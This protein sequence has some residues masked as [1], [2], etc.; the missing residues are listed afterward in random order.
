MELYLL[1][2]EYFYPLRKKI[3]IKVAIID[4]Y[5]NV[6]EH[7]I[8]S[9]KS[10]DRY[11]ITIFNE[12]FVNEDE[13]VEALKDF[14]ALMIMRERTPITKSLISE[15]KKLKFIFTS[16]MRNR[17]IDFEAVNKKNIIVCGTDI[18]SNPAAEITWALI[19]GLAKNIKQETDNMFQGYWQTTIGTELKNKTLGL[20]GLGKIGKQ[21][22]KIG[23]AFGMQVTAWSENL[24]LRDA[25]D[26]SVLPM[27]KEDIL[28]NSDYIS[29]HVVLGDRYRNLIT[30]K[31]FKI[32]KKTAFLINT[33][34]GPIVN[35]NDL[36]NAL[37]SNIIAGAGLDVF[38][39]EPLPQDHKLRFLPNA[40]LLPHLGYVTEENYSIF[41]TQMLENLKACLL[42]KPIRVITK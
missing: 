40:L 27:S 5:Q 11:E 34:R 13:V 2:E 38:D 31:D 7:F 17:S 4:D 20:I 9:S 19:L 22:A 8:N 39:Q 36:I 21:V 12:P 37:K 6:S 14:D 15:L 25:S 41:Y 26:L 10:E 33:S 29:I 1:L 30:E 42:G 35:E 24:N 32:M 23:Q 18:N 3:M 16:G 28:K